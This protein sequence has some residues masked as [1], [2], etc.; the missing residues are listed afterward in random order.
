MKSRRRFFFRCFLLSLV[1]IVMVG[2]GILYSF[3]DPDRLQ[4]FVLTEVRKVLPEEAATLKVG[5]VLYSDGLVI[6]D[7]SVSTPGPD[8]I[9]L[10][11]ADQIRL[12]LD[13]DAIAMGTIQPHSVLIEGLVL[14]I[15]RRSDKSWT[16]DDLL[17]AF[18]TS[19]SAPSDDGPSESSSESSSEKHMP[20]I[21]ISNAK[22]HYRDQSNP[23]NSPASYDLSNIRAILTGGSNSPSTGT[24]SIQFSIDGQGNLLQSFSIFGVWNSMDSTLQLSQFAAELDLSPENH[25]KMI[26]PEKIL[27]RIKDYKIQGKVKLNGRASA[28]S[29]GIKDL[30]VTVTIVQGN[31]TLP[32][33]GF[34]LSSISAV[35]RYNDDILTIERLRG[36]SSAGSCEGRGRLEL[37]LGSFQPGSTDLM[38]ILPRVV[39]DD[40][41]LASIPSS[42]KNILDRYQIRGSLTLK[43]SVK[44]GNWKIKKSQ[45]E[46]RLPSWP[47]DLGDVSLE[48]TPR[49]LDFRYDQFPYLVEILEGKI[50][51][52]EGKILVD[53]PL[54]GIAGTGQ[55]TV[56]GSMALEKTT[57]QSKS[58]KVSTINFLLKVMGASVS[59]AIPDALPPKIKKIWDTFDP[60][61]TG[62]AEL[63]FKW[64][65][66]NSK[67]HTVLIVVPKNMKFQYQHFPINVDHLKGKFL[68]DFHDHFI[69]LELSGRHR[70][71][72]IT[73]K[74]VIHFAPE[75]NTMDI[76]INCDRFSL[77]REILAAL[78]PGVRTPLQKNRVSGES[79]VKVILH[80][81]GKEDS[82]NTR[83]EVHMK[84]FI[85]HPPTIPFPLILTGGW[86][87]I[88]G[89]NLR[90]HGLKGSGNPDFEINGNVDEDEKKVHVK[91]HGNVKNL[92]L[93][94]R[95][96]A[97]FNKEARKK[98][99]AMNLLGI[100]DFMFE[101]DFYYR[102]DPEIPKD[103]TYRIFGIQSR[104][105][106]L[107]L[108]LGLSNVILEGEVT[109]KGSMG[110]FHNLEGK[111]RI[112]TATFNRLQFGDAN[113]HFVYGKEHPAVQ[114]GRNNKS[115]EGTSYVVRPGFIERLQPKI[116]N[117]TLQLLLDPADLYGGIVQG[118]FFADLGGLG[119][120]RGHILA[121]DI[122]I[123]RAAPGIFK[124]EKL[125]T[126]GVGSGEVRFSGITGN[127]SSIIGEGSGEVKGANFS[128]LP[129]FS[130]AVKYVSR[131]EKSGLEFSD[132]RA[133][134]NIR[135]EKFHISEGEI[136]LKGPVMNLRGQGSMNF[137]GILNMSFVPE[138][139]DFKF[140]PVDWI[141]KNLAKVSVT[142]PLENPNTTLVLLSGVHL[143]L[144]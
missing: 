88:D 49:S 40:K 79:R 101:T 24:S 39:I 18:Q 141:K 133:K 127:T 73:G 83:V 62:D 44:S 142:G 22:I 108:G 29:D 120:M 78:P 121:K 125:K 92:V 43:G 5:S 138:I 109:G 131:N 102:A 58:W 84:N 67:V 97:I 89:K 47:P 31:V 28:S 72:L 137:Y 7:I 52:S 87:E 55:A 104:D 85:L 76:T 4:Q 110:K 60:V 134:Y 46:P 135:A 96:M 2:I 9:T 91:I 6:K 90:L 56:T 80:R 10:F 82:V 106:G 37:P 66:E 86:V 23:E 13:R 54:K 112:Q 99:R 132:L 17:K 75:M 100:H 94:E 27:S 116:L 98:F 124:D 57:G 122:D 140:T 136:L 34:N 1:L 16:H 42:L 30:D 11:Q 139:F 81:R 105:L 129:V 15:A 14:N 38:I 21:Q 36:L 63:Q 19:D 114:A 143:P 41:L 117:K 107:D 77:N 35:A 119:E 64:D 93:D 53:S 115:L 20:I 113:L 103:Y 61:G 144:K 50:I 25:S 111:M 123:S 32:S 69:D 48:I 126:T 12:V 59:S 8:S 65:P 95:L 26:L 68:L 118:F 45:T 33:C 74:G 130:K 70:R 51:L 71:R 3:L 128:D